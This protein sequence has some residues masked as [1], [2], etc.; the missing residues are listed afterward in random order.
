[1]L[2][3][4]R[5][6]DKPKLN[7]DNTNL[8]S[9]ARFEEEM[10]DMGTFYVLIGKEVNEEVEILEAALS[11]VK[12][13]WDVFPEELLEGLPPLRDIQQQIDLKPGAMLPNRPHYQMSPS[14]HEKL[15]RP[16]EE[17]L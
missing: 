2:L 12:K 17:L 1:M 9:L 15:R 4:N 8:L 14:E 5:D 13:F 11:L 3:S 6:F 10:R 16:V 7:G